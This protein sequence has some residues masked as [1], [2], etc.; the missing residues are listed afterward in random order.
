MRYGEEGLER[1]ASRR[2]VVRPAQNVADF[3]EAARLALDVRPQ[4]CSTYACI[5]AALEGTTT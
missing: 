2:E 5:T 4:H 1:R 3:V